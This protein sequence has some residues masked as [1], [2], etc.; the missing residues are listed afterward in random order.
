MSDREGK[1]PASL[2]WEGYFLQVH[3]RGGIDLRWEGKPIDTIEDAVEAA[4]IIAANTDID[5]LNVSGGMCY[6][7]RP[8]HKEPGYFG[9]IQNADFP[10][11]T[12]KVLT[13]I[14]LRKLNT[15]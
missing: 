2:T 10:L 1:R 13:G 11:Y 12:K 3:I 15:K 14:K 8:D 7:K 5:I 4:K 6:Y 9:W